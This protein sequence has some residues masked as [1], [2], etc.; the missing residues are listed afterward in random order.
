MKAIVFAVTVAATLA[1]G[2]T[3]TVA[4]P[5]NCQYSPVYAPGPADLDPDGDGT[6]VEP[7]QSIVQHGAVIGYT[8]TCSGIESDEVQP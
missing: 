4:G 6:W 5:L 1:L 8:E 3:T 2:S 7:G